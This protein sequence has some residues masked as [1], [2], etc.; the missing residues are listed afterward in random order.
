MAKKGLSNHLLGICIQIHI[1]YAWKTSKAVFDLILDSLH[2]YIPVTSADTIL[3]HI[4]CLS[5]KLS[6]PSCTSVSISVKSLVL[7]RAKL[8]LPLS[9]E[10]KTS[11][12]VLKKTSFSKTNFFKT[13]HSVLFLYSL[14]IPPLITNFHCTILGEGNIC[15]RERWCWLGISTTALNA[16]RK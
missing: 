12:L 4:S 14:P 6:R 1:C 8:G 2:L 5:P 3:I 16:N 11:L 7:S 15:K 10:K 13:K 9:P